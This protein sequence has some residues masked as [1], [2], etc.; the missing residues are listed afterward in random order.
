VGVTAAF[1]YRCDKCG[2]EAATTWPLV[3]PNGEALARMPESW[4]EKGRG[5]LRGGRSVL[6]HGCANPQPQ[7]ATA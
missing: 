1:V 2:C 5:Y 6:C 4:E 7:A 3:R